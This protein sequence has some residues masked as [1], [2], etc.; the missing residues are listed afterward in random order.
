M[1]EPMQCAASLK[2]RGED[3]RQNN[4]GDTCSTSPASNTSVAS[5]KGGNEVV[6]TT[7][8]EALGEFH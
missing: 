6:T 1:Y 8:Q 2:Y 4:P 5:A 3:T 7:K